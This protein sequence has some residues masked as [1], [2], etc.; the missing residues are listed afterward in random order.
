MFVNF[1]LKVEEARSRGLD[2]TKVF[3]KEFNGYKDELRKPYLPD[4]KITDSLVR[5]TYDRMKEEVNASHILVALKP[6]PS[7]GGHT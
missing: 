6:D 4:A 2:T 5:L 1:K 7:P 3:V